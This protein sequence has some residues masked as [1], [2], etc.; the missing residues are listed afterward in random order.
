M[1][2][3]YRKVT[4]LIIDSSAENTN[5]TNAYWDYVAVCADGTV[6]RSPSIQEPEW[7]RV[8]GPPLDE[9]EE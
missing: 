2:D 3:K 6:W 7:V 4:Q 1:N 5:A 9:V 8:D